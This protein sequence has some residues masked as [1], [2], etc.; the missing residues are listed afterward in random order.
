MKVWAKNPD[1]K[2]NERFSGWWNVWFKDKL[3][4][5]TQGEENARIAIYKHNR[6]KEYVN[7]KDFEEVEDGK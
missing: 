1:Y 5:I 3:I 6:E 7:E 4:A 2:I